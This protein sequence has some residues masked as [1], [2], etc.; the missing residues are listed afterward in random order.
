MYVKGLENKLDAA[1]KLI[2]EQE[3]ILLKLN[4]LLDAANKLLREQSLEVEE[5]RTRIH[6][7]ENEMAGLCCTERST[8]Q[9]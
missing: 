3:K 9:V 8:S 2:W 5:C 1:N 6:Q 7:L 4:A